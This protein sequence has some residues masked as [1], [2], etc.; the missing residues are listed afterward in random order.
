MT[1]SIDSFREIAASERGLCVV[2]MLRADGTIVA[3]VVNAGVT[4][5]PTGRSDVVG[6][7]A[8]GTRKLE[9]LRA[10]PRVT[11]V[12]RAGWRWAAVEG[13]ASL[14]GPE[15]P[16]PDIDRRGPAEPASRCVHSGWRDPRRLGRLRQGDGRR[17]Q[18]CRPDLP[19]PRLSQ[20]EVAHDA[21]ARVRANHTRNTSTSL[22]RRCVLLRGPRDCG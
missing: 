4:Q 20:F 9:H 21:V 16:Q 17:A 7:V 2:S 1:P 19:D 22:P 6:F 14:Y 18:R 10:D 3:S 11:V 8:R 13:T 5:H 12:A 15:D